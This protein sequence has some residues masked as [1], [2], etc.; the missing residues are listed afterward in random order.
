V[1]LFIY[2]DAEVETLTA[3]QTPNPAGVLTTLVSF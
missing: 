2:V 3:T 1:D